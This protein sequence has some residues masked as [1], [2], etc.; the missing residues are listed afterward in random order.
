MAKVFRFYQTVM[1]MMDNTKKTKNTG[2]GSILGRMEAD[3]KEAGM[4]GRCMAFLKQSM[5][6]GFQGGIFGSQGL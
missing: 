2:L 1:F 6:K 4:M 3:T 5:Q